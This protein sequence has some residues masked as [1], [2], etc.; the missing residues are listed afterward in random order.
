MCMCVYADGPARL[1]TVRNV[2]VEN[3]LRSSLKKSNGGFGFGRALERESE[4][5]DGKER[6]VA[7]DER[8]AGRGS[9]PAT[10]PRRCRHRPGCDGQGGRKTGRDATGRRGCGG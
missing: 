8:A 7:R 1:A 5:E 2:R 4:D 6:F 9:A 3:V 10:A